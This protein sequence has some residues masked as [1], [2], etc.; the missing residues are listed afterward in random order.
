LCNPGD[1]RKA[2]K[3]EM[4]EEIGEEKEKIKDHLKGSTKS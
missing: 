4:R 1:Y 2:R 3:G